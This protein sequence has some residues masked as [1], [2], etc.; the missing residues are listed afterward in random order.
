MSGTDCMASFA[1]RFYIACDNTWDFSASKVHPLW[2]ASLL[3]GATKLHSAPRDCLLLSLVIGDFFLDYSKKGF[4]S[5]PGCFLVRNWEFTE[6]PLKGFPIWHVVKRLQTL[7]VEFGKQA[8]STEI[9]FSVLIK[10]NCMEKGSSPVC[11]CTLQEGPL[12][13]RDTSL[14]FL[15][16][17]KDGHFILFP[18]LVNGQLL[19]VSW[20]ALSSH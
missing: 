2:S 18:L 10:L 5:L 19:L 12:K 6:F 20:I 3:W 4:L 16:S 15:L 8:S 1:A 13:T 7:P 14:P 17:G 9:S 11:L